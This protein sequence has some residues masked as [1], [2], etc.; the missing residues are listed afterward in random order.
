LHN[1]LLDKHHELGLQE[2]A[3]INFKFVIVNHFKFI[4]P[5][6]K[7]Y[8]IVPLKTNVDGTSTLPRC[9]FCVIIEVSVAKPWLI[10]QMTAQR[11]EH[12]FA[13]SVLLLVDGEHDA[14]GVPKLAVSVNCVKHTCKSLWKVPKVKGKSAVRRP[15]L[16]FRT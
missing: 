12:K 15:F 2:T 9:S 6:V 10:S 8:L 7:S 13:T 1:H 14:V 16:L 3:V 11:K 5:L 4:H